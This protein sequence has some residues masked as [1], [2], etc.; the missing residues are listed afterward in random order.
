MFTPFLLLLAGAAAAAKKTATARWINTW[1]AMPQLTEFNNLPPAPFNGTTNVF[2]NSTIRQTLHMSIGGDTIRIRFSNAFGVNNLNIAAA[3]VALPAGGV[4]GASAV[5]PA[6]IQP[7]TFSGNPTFS[8]PNAGIV[9][10]DPISFPIKPQQTITVT[11]Y[12]AGGQNGFSITSHPG[13]R[14]TTWLQLGNAVSAENITGPSVTSLAHWYFV[15]AVETLT[16]PSASAFFI[17]GDSIT[18]GRGSDTDGNDRWPDLLLARMQKNAPTSLISVNN[19]AA[20][21]NRILADGLGPAALGRIERD[22]LAQTG[23]VK[24]AMIFEGVN[25]IGTADTS[26]T[27]QQAVGDQLIA[28]FKQIST[29]VHAQGIPF[30]AGT[31]TPFS[32]PANVTIQPYSNPIREKQR[33]RINT[34]IRTSPDVFDAVVDFDKVIADPQIPSQL[35]SQFNSGD[36]LHP[37]VAGYTAMAAAF[38]LDLFAKFADG[39]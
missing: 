38:P 33:Q 24:Y 35:A 12:L 22:V 18:D 14:A 28:A 7:L 4:S 29:I 5:I 9:V 21:G 20:G 25:D 34:F 2:F 32:A 31:I 26:E 17:V 13:S 27:T 10:S 30:F 6:S 15:S 1:T 19:Q 8:I 3:T 23:K 16:T 37:N 36:F 39:V 11:L